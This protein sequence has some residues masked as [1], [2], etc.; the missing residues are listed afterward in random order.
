MFLQNK[1]AL[2]LRFNQEDISISENEDI[3]KLWL[4]KVV[5]W[6]V[7]FKNNFFDLS[8]LIGLIFEIQCFRIDIVMRV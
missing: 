2:M 4:N 6:Y 5:L 8:V 7:Y 1:L 3:D